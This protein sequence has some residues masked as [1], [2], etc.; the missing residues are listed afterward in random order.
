[1]AEAGRFGPASAVDSGAPAGHRNVR[2]GHDLAPGA[3]LS[4]LDLAPPKSSGPAVRDF[5]GINSVEW[6]DDTT[7]QLDLSHGGDGDIPVVFRFDGEL[8]I[9]GDPDDL[10]HSC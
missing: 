3:G 4:D 1:M 9:S 8:T 7:L 6:L 2:F 5:S 10:L